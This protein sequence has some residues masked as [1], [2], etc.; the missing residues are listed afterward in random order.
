MNSKNE[1]DETISDSKE[2]SL[3]KAMLILEQN[4]LENENN[5]EKIRRPKIN[6][7]KIVL[8]L[9]IV[10]VLEIFFLIIS[11]FCLKK[12][13]VVS[14]I[15]LGLLVIIIILTSKKNIINLILLYQ[16]YAPEKIRMSCLFEPTCSEYMILAIKKYGIIKGIYKGIKRLLR[17]HSPNGGIDYP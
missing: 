9:I 15:M 6:T 4:I 11:I 12:Y 14:F 10:A 3:K 8:D 5:K 13:I 2:E 7:K 17:C 1:Y 16:K